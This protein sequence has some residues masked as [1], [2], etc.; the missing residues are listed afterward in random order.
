MPTW[1]VLAEWLILPFPM[2]G[3][4]FG[5]LLH[6]FVLGVGWGMGAERQLTELHAEEYR[7]RM[8][9]LY[10]ETFTVNARHGPE[11]VVKYF[12]RVQPKAEGGH[13]PECPGENRFE[14]IRA[15]QFLIDREIL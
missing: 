7:G 12:A 8:I 14:A 11:T 6:G 10:Q 15:A 1:V 3:T 5:P 9:T 4:V 13:T 2:A